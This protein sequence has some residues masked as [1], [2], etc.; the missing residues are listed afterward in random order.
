MFSS[1]AGLQK[2][3]CLAGEENSQFSSRADAVGEVG[4]VA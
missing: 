1:L 2:R 3:E 4:Q